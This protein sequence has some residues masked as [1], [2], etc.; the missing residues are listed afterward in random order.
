M[1]RTRFFCRRKQNDA[2]HR[3]FLEKNYKITYACPA[4]FSEYAVNLEEMGIEQVQIEANK[5]EFDSWLKKLNPEIVMFD[6]FMM[7]E[8][9]GWRI[10]RI[11][12]MHCGF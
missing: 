3:S 11:A 2:T 4:K 1:A 6:R 10:A 7:E 12:P 9:F 8:Q 5:S